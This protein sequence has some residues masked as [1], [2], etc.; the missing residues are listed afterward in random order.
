LATEKF[1]VIVVGAGP[2]GTSTALSLAR[3][4]L[5]VL[6]IERGEFPG[7]KNMFGGVFYRW[8]LNELIP[9]FTELAP[10]ER[11]ITEYRLMMLSPDSG[12]TVSYRD[13]S[14]ASP[15]FNSFTVSRAKFDKWFASVAEEAGVLVACSVTVED[16]IKEDGKVVGVRSGPG[17]ED[18]AYADV[19]VAADGVNSNLAVKAG[20][21][22]PLRPEQVA[23]GVKEVIDLGVDLID[24]RFN[25]KRNAGVATTV[26]GVTHGKMGGG[27]IYTNDSSVSVGI[28]ILLS[29]LMDLRMEPYAILDEFENHPL[30]APMLDGGKR[31]EYSAHLIPEAGY[32]SRPR[33][34]T[35]GLLLVGDAAFLCDLL[36]FEC[37]NMAV[38]SGII[39]AEAIARAKADRDFSARSLRRY[40]QLLMSHYV[41]KELRRRRRVPAFFSSNPRLFG[42]YPTLLNRSVR[43][44]LAVDGTTKEEKR[45]TILRNVRREVGYANLIRDALKMRVLLP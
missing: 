24:S 1:D 11:F 9:N 4:G 18:E 23:L 34:Y 44:I 29:H 15:P 28:V 20:L 12:L 16:L 3:R 27:F 6:M 30:I 33:I 35:D 36:Y 45:K 25:V 40:E 7:A 8:P 21:R 22:G 13:P 41:M 37:T 39:A 38:A 43:S 26:L 14:L 2:A 42:A 10:I 17:G 5:S 31:K 32:D 19:V